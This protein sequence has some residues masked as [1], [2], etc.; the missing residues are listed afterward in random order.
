VEP[1]AAQRIDREKKGEART[2]HQRG[3]GEQEYHAGAE[4]RRSSA[5]REGSPREQRGREN[6]EQREKRMPGLG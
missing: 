1:L 3:G 2:S 4:H 6:R 5:A